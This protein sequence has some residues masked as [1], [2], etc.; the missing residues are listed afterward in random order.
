[1]I[2]HDHIFKNPPLSFSGKGGFLE[3][4]LT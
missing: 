2:L 3:G 1:M 4:R